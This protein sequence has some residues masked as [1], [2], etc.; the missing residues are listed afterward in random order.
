[1]NIAFYLD[2]MNFRGVAN[3]VFQY[4]YYNEKILKNKSIIFYNKKNRFNKKVVIDK[5][6]KRFPVIGVDNFIDIEKFH[7]KYNLE[8]IYVQKGGEK[9]N[10]ISKKIKTLIHCVYPQYLKHLHG[11]KYAYISE[12]L[13]KKFSNRKLPYVPYIIELSKNNNT[14]RK[15]LKIKTKSIVFG[16]HGGESSFDLLFVKDSLLKI[17]KNRKDIFFIFLNINKFCNH[18][19]IIFLKGT[20]NENYKRSFL[21]TCDAMIYGR[22]LGESFG[23]SC[24]EFSVLGKKII[25]YRYNR[26]RSHEFNTNKNAFVEYSNKKELINIIQSFKKIKKGKNYSKYLLYTPKKVMNTFNDVFLK[27]S[28]KTNLDLFDYSINHFSFLALYYNYLKHKIYNH[29]YNLIK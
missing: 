18:R 6:K 8:Y 21:N 16:C 28:N 20:A 9:D 26:H 2:E 22:S 29:Y 4:S 11:Y 7:K 19:Q 3:S 12:W 23:L 24:G 1:M 27:K 10:W 14:L 17:V 15:K 13:S 5:F 25:S